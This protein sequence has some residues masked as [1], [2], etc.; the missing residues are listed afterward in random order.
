MGWHGDMAPHD[1]DVLPRRTKQLWNGIREASC[2]HCDSRYQNG[3]F[4]SLE[5]KVNSAQHP[6]R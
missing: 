1:H 4:T 6:R 2:R 3:W 5:R